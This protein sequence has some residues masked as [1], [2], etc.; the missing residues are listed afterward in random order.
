M[1]AVVMRQRHPKLV[2]ALGQ[3]NDRLQGEKGM[4]KAAIGLMPLATGAAARAD[5]LRDLCADRPGKGSP[6]CTVD[7]GHLQ[8]E[9]GVADWSYD[10]SADSIEDDLVLGDIALRYGLGSSTELQL[11]WTAYGHVRTKDRASGIVSRDHGSGDVTI[12]VRQNLH[13]PD[14]SGL[15]IAVQ[16]FVT[17]PA[18]GH[19]IGAGTWGAGLVVPVSYQLPSN[20]QLGFTGEMDAAPDADR[21]GRHTAYS[22]SVGVSAP[23][24]KTLTGSAEL[25][26]MRDRDPA[27]HSS[28]ASLDLAV[29]WIP[30][31]KGR[32]QFDAG[33]YVGLN[34]KTPDV[35]TYVGVT[36]KF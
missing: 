10:R 32:L 20:I 24:T 3:R 35:E 2:A 22:A 29:A 1:S 8:V 16:P 7:P 13:N 18:G 11:G 19:A 9:F 31:A 5:D 30:K 21:H 28:Q 12:G 33:T 23:V 4:I 14:G 36:E 34:R 15:S 6:A 27:G 17:L 25:W 26:V